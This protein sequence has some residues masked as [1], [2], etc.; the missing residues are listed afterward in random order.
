MQTVIDKFSG[1]YRFLSNFYPSI[2]NVPILYSGRN[3]KDETAIRIQYIDFPTVEHAYVATKSM[4]P[5]FQ[6]KVASIE[7]AGD[8]KRLGRTVDLRS[9][10]ERVKYS[11]MHMLVTKKFKTHDDLA[12]MLLMTFNAE[13]IEGNTWGDTYWGVC[14]GVG[15]NNLGEILMKVRRSLQR[16]KS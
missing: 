1:E 4:D 14:N 9:D 8:V 6:L 10:W 5:D 16:E 13:L 15:E 7:K 12:H 11:I 2:I 3:H